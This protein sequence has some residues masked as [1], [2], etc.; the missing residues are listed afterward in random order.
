MQRKLN[1]VKPRDPVSIGAFDQALQNLVAELDQQPAPEKLLDESAN[2]IQNLCKA[3][4]DAMLGQ[5]MEDNDDR[6]QVET[7]LSNA[8]YEEAL[9]IVMI[10]LSAS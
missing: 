9:Q 5:F 2:L 1:Q 8:N 10:S 6:K 4:K 3:I 7:L